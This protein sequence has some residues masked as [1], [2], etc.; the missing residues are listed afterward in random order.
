MGNGTANY[1]IIEETD[2]YLVIQDL[3]PH[4][5]YQTVTNAVEW[6]VNQL[7][8]RLGDR[9]LYYIDSSNT[10]DQIVVEDGRFKTFKSGGPEGW[11]NN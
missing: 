4:Y 1:R 6:V 2:E 7:M 11:A 3:G 5:E 10:M 8:D 9:E